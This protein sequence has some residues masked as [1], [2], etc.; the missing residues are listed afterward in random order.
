MKLMATTPPLDRFTA[1]RREF[2]DAQTGRR[3]WQV[4]DGEFECIAPYMDKIA[5][6]PDDRYLV[7][8]SNRTG[9][10]QPYRL[11]LATGEALQLTH[12]RQGGFRSVALSIKGAEAYC[13][14]GCCLK[15]VNIQNLKERLAV[16]WGQMK[17]DGGKAGEK[18]PDDVIV[19]A[20]GT[21]ALSGAKDARGNPGFVV[22]PTDGANRFTLHSLPRTDITPGHSL[23]CPGDDQIISFHGYPDRQNDVNETPDHR[24]GQWRYDCRSGKMTPLAQVPPGFRITH[25]LWSLSG[26][27]FYFHRKT[28]PGWV[29]TALC[30]VNREGGD[31]RVHYETGRHKLGHCTPSPGEQWIVTDSQDR[32]ANIV[33]LC[34]A[35]GSEQH[36]LCWP[37]NSIKQIS[38]AKRNPALPPHTDTDIHPGFSLSGRYI[39]YTSDGSGRSQV[40][41]AP[42]EDL[43]KP[44]A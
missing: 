3:I 27:R 29:P 33:M 22:V 8:E 42:V 41:V 10:W 21:L 31:F 38:M 43:V 34:R 30:S 9:S 20:S 36:L 25:S 44:G 40:Y 32:P 35:D 39:H 17:R 5:W 19:N 7:I 28:V 15:A 23:F 6:T 24:V 13:G 37:N 18:S 16:N 2:D 11:E 14:D 12:N 4:T 1:K 26:N